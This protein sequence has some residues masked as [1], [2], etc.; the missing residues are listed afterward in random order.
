[1]KSFLKNLGGR[2]GEGSNLVGRLFQIGPYQVKVESKLAEGGYASIFRVREVDKGT[3]FGMKLIRVQG[4]PEALEEV[5]VEARVMQQL[6]G[7]PHI[8]RLHAVALT[9]PKGSEDCLMLLDICEHSLVDAARKQLLDPRAG[10]EAFHHVCKAVAY[11]HEQSPPLAHRS[12][13]HPLPH[14]RHIAHA[15]LILQQPLCL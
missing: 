13:P 7:H 14:A 3:V 1:M 9:G 11:M 8:L 10:L 4:N 6:R 15:F 5:K 12:C 2:P